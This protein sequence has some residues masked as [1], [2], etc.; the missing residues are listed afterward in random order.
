MDAAV[1]DGEENE[2]MFKEID[3]SRPPS[4]TRV[5]GPRGQLGEEEGVHHS[6]TRC[7]TRGGILMEPFTPVE[8]QLHVEIDDLKQAK[9]RI[10]LYLQSISSRYFKM[11]HHVTEPVGAVEG[12][13]FTQGYC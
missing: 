4:H 7:L 11:A 12:K 1:V 2:V 3:L 8:D 6:H 5:A 13:E 10:S 9:R